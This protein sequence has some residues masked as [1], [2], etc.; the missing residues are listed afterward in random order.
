MSDL[1]PQNQ[2]RLRRVFRFIDD[3][4]PLSPGLDELSAP[5]M[6]SSGQSRANSW[7]V[8]V[9]AFAVVL[10]LAIPAAFLINPGSASDP[11][12]SPTPTTNETTTTTVTNPAVTTPER[13]PLDGRP[14]DLGVDHI[15]FTGAVLPASIQE[16]RMLAVWEAARSNVES[17]WVESCME[18][19]GTTIEIPRITA[20][21]LR[22]Q[23]AIP[24]FELDAEFGFFDPAP[25]EWSP[26]PPADSTAEEA[27]TW[28]RSYADC[29]LEAEAKR[30][31]QFD[32][33]IGQAPSWMAIVDEVTTSPEMHAVTEQMLQCIG[34]AAGPDVDTVSELYSDRL[35]KE[36]DSLAA[37]GQASIELA[38]LIEQCAGNYD[39]TRKSLLLPKREAYM[40]EHAEVLATAEFYFIEVMTEAGIRISE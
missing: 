10:V 15:D 19:R 38:Q 14:S 26:V 4:A 27:A 28:N 40:D 32:Q 18:A 39:A 25:D 35:A 31:E 20:Y 30:S 9:S 6:T 33:V 12:G 5:S 3:E 7:W 16:I 1:Q 36:A 2:A 21:E 17:G 37:A 22:R 11:L 24:D 13:L 23:A 29:S 8:A 34:D